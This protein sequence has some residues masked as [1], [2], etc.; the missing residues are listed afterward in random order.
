[1][2]DIDP[3]TQR[4]RTEE[5]ARIENRILAE[6]RARVRDAEADN[7]ARGPGLPT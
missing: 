1:M 5:M 3:E 6:E 7:D 4:A 2:T